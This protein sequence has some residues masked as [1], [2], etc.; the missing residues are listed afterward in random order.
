MSGVF[1]YSSVTEVEEAFVFSILRLTLS[2][3]RPRKAEGDLSLVVMLA[4]F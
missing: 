2:G 3:E 4:V 1:P